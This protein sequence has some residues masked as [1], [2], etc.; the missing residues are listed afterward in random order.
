ME[1]IRKENINNI[2][3]STFI[4]SYN[5]FLAFQ[6]FLGLTTVNEWEDATEEYWKGEWTSVT[7]EYWE[8]YS[9]K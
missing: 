5:R 2:Y 7:R 6:D 8:F 1:R 4:W 9:R 3:F